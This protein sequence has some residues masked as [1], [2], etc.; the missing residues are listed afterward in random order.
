MSKNWVGKTLGKVH[1]DSLLAR[2]GMA[3]V[4]L[5]THINLQRTVAVKILRNLNEDSQDALDRFQREA[6]VVAK[7][8][9]PN[10]VQV[11]D[12]DTIDNEPYL[13][14]EYVKGPS[15]S[16]YLKALHQNNERLDLPKVVRLLNAV[17]SA[18]QYAHNSGVIHR[19]VK[20]GNILLTSPTSP[21]V[22]DKPLPDDFEPVLT[23]FGLVRF[24]DAQ[25]QTTTGHIAGTPAY[26]SPEQA[27]GEITDGRTDVYSLGIVL[28]E[29]LAG[30]LPFEGETTMSILLKHITETPPPIPGLHPLLESVLNRALA[31]DLND[32][33]QTPMEFANA[34]RVAVE[35]I[36][37]NLPHDHFTLALDHSAHTL[38]L[39]E[40]AK[41]KIPK[42]PW[43]RFAI[44]GAAAITLS[45]FL[46]FNNN[47]FSPPPPTETL[48]PT[49][50]LPTKTNT[51]PPP[52]FT[53]GPTAFL[54]FQNGEAIADQA[55]LIAQAM[56]VLPE[57]NQYEVWLIGDNESVSLGILSLDVTGK[58]ELIFL[59]A[60]GSNLIAR[61]HRVEITVE[62]TSD[63]D[64]QPSG[65]VAYS[66]ILPPDGILHLRYLLSSFP[67]TPDKKALIQGL[68]TNVGLLN[69][70]AEEL[71]SEIKSGNKAAAQEKA[72]AI[73]NLILGAQNPNHKD[74]DR[75]GKI[76]ENSDGYG[77]LLNGSNLGYLQAVYAEADYAVN[78][79]G[80]SQPM[81]THGE[82]VKICVQNLALWT[83]QLQ[84]R[85]I[86]ILDPSSAANFEQ[87]VPEVA[88]LADQMF[89]GRDV[90]QN[91]EIELVTGEC[92]AKAAYEHAYYMADMPLLPTGIIGIS[93]T[94]GT[95]T[96]LTVILYTPTGAR[97]G[98]S[99]ANTPAPPPGNNP[100]RTPPGQ[101]RTQRPPPGQ[102][103]NPPK[104]P[105]NNS[106]NPNN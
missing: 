59:D 5:G 52:L 48:T 38:S 45:A 27:R 1:V 72:E 9:H 44:V 70:L 18:L 63:S 4:Y 43:M 21:V 46:L 42:P 2:G 106:G 58:G 87:L 85:V 105:N 96:P 7:L 80:A 8:R 53:L 24:L 40:A 50:P 30:H 77:L 14:M 20:P 60:T 55:S 65:L 79:P 35:M 71:Q 88:A 92:G 17:A 11:F 103:D 99:E 10:I 26:M 76:A 28:Y 29:I 51:Q 41:P 16:K 64:P 49:I 83:A 47:V 84:E 23:D 91:G 12:F 73:L 62:P 3:E 39:P 69:E 22:I 81:I 25:R 56:P 102:E 61:Y 66:Y 15:L 97:D 74:W 94:N 82:H 104:K 78:L 32:R 101:V 75:N 57:G 33:F 100:P 68:Y 6:R 36:S 31:K 13:V 98:G 95:G 93:N 67:N 34:F 19:D 86:A 89:N 90:N 54:R 37:E